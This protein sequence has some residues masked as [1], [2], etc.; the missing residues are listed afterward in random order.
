MDWLRN[1]AHAPWIHNALTGQVLPHAKEPAEFA[2]RKFWLSYLLVAA[3]TQA[4]P[5]GH[6]STLVGN[7]TW[8]LATVAVL[9][10]LIDFFRQLPG[11]VRKALAGVKFPVLVVLWLP[12]NP[13]PPVPVQR[14]APVSGNADPARPLALRI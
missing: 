2:R 1:L 8:S 7:L 10:A 4:W 13:K 14:V 6:Q 5:V 12:R 9:W 11:V 3:I